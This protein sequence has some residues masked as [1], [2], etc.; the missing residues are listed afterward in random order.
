MKVNK[1]FPKQT[2]IR[3]AEMK[4][5]DQ[6]RFA[7][8]M[9]TRPFSMD[10]ADRSL[11]EIEADDVTPK[12]AGFD[13]FGGLP[14]EPAAE[15]KMVGIVTVQRFGHRP[16]ISFG[17]TS[18]EGRQITDHRGLVGARGRQGETGAA[19]LIPYTA[20]STGDALLDQALGSR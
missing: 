8:R 18:S 4:L 13:R 10:I 1:A 2:A 15:I 9:E 12:P 20:P 11:V 5:A 14:G 19:Q 3:R 6:S 7:Q 16:E 17:K